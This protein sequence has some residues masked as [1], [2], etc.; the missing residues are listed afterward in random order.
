M[1]SDCSSYKSLIVIL[2]N[3]QVI[4]TGERKK[5]KNMHGNSIQIIRGILGQSQKNLLT[6][7]FESNLQILL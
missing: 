2:N 4:F 3:T 5:S 6:P 1:T 7:R